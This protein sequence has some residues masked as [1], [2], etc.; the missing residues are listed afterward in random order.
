MMKGHPRQ[1][2]A[3]PLALTLVALALLFLSAQPAA[4]ATPAQR[5]AGQTV[6]TR[7]PNRHHDSETETPTA[8]VEPAAATQTAEATA[9]A[10]ATPT[11]TED[12][13]PTPE[14]DQGDR[15]N[16]VPTGQ[17]QPLRTEHQSGERHDLD[18][19]PWSLSVPDGAI[20]RDGAIEFRLMQP[21]GVPAANSGQVLIGIATDLTLFDTDGKPVTRPTFDQPVQVCF[22][23]SP[24]ELARA[25]GDPASLFIQFYDV[26]AGAWV[27]LPTTANAANQRVCAPVTHFTLFSVAAKVAVPAALPITGGQADPTTWLWVLIA[28]ALGIGGGLVW[29]ARRAQRLPPEQPPAK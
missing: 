28:L 8:T 21:N 6:P 16:C 22:S 1:R 2:L 3:R 25:G 13:G 23:Y 20:N 12:R 27:A 5:P 26:N 24:N 15:R 19:C 11:A 14:A 7:T 9:I 29:R 10:T 18:N 4:W 17:P